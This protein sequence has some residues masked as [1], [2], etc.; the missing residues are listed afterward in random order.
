MVC[1]IFSPISTDSN[2]P[3]VTSDHK[4]YMLYF[5][6]DQGMFVQLHATLK[7]ISHFVGQSTT[8]FSV[9]II[10]MLAKVIVSSMLH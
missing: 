6:N 10:Y 5:Q 4:S 3:L 9:A 2:V 1:L 7:F 8:I